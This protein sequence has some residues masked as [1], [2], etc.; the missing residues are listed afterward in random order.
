MAMCNAFTVPEGSEILLSAPDFQLRCSLRLLFRSEV[1][2]GKCL[3]L[4]G[5]AGKPIARQIS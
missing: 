4:P 2:L 5:K 1:E 3:N